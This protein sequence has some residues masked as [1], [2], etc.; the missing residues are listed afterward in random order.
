[1]VFLLLFA[2][3]STLPPIPDTR[4]AD[5]AGQKLE[6]ATAGMLEAA[7]RGRSPL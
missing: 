1:M 2:G 4:I 7:I 3:C 5:V 6:Y